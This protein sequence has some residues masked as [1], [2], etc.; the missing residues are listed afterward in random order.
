MLFWNVLVALVWAALNASFKPST[1]FGGF[2]A[3]YLILY[4]LAA[5]GVVNGGRYFTMGRL[6]MGTLLW[7][8][9]EVIKSNV[10][11]A[12]ELFRNYKNMKPGIIAYPLTVRTE[13]EISLLATMITLTPGTMS[14]DVSTDRSVLYIH[15]MFLGNYAEGEFEKEIRDSFERRVLALFGRSAA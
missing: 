1:L 12:V 8:V 10:Y 14:V 2:L 6:I 15:S 5:T 3:G 11:L 7:F 9:K 4:L 13:A